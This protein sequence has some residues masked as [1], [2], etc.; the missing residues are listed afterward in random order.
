ML[1]QVMLGYIK[2]GEFRPRIYKFG[3]VRKVSSG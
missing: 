2:K 3:Q 1:V